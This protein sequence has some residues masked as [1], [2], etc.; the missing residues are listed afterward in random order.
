MSDE[1]KKALEADGEKL[2]A[3]TGRDHGPWSVEEYFDIQ[4]RIR[5]PEDHHVICDC[6]ICVAWYGF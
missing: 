5:P 1:M 4:D 2:K 6:E 3:L